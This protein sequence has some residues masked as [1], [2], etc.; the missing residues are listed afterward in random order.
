[1]NIYVIGSGFFGA[2]IAERIAADA[3]IPVTVIE[4]R[5]HVGGNSWSE[6]CPDTGIECHKYGSHIFHTSDEQV[7]NYMCRF[8]GFNNYRHKVLTTYNENVYTM[9]I[10]LT[11]INSFY[12][13]SL[14]SS[15]VST[16]IAG[17]AA[18]EKIDKPENLEEKAVSL[19]GR[20]L[21]EAFIKGYTIKQWDKDPRELSSGIISRL[22]VRNDD[23]DRYFS[24]KYEGIPLD[25]YGKLFAEILNHDLISVKLNTDFFAVRDSIPPDS[26]ILYTGAIDQF[27]DYCHGKLEWRTSTFETDIHDFPDYQGTTVMNYASHEIPYT[28]IHEFKHYHPERPSTDKTITYTEYSKKSKDKDEPYYPVATE[29]NLMI[30]EKYKKDAA[31]LNNVIFG[32]RLGSYKYLD[33]D[34]AISEALKCYESRVVPLLK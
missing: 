30:L 20:P 16:F 24:D 27:F 12:G 11:T 26:L 31:K 15:E 34:D 6:I 19:I 10:N 18:K 33:M 8:T 13:L 22:P 7:W 17:E 3:G 5:H 25:G 21:Y 4:K 23:N 2:V 14:T 32:G 28:R 1:M 29:R 9:P